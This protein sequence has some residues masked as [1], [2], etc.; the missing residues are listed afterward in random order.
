MGW[1]R[2]SER[3][4][5]HKALATCQDASI[6]LRNFSQKAHR[7]INRS[8]CMVSEGSSL[9][10]RPVSSIPAFTSTIAEFRGFFYLH[11]LGLWV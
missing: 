9:H 5:G 11:F 8:R 7:F 4:D 3:H 6:E 10:L 1:P 2:Q